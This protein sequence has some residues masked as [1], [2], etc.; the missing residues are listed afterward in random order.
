MIIGIDMDSV[1]ADLIE[2]LNRFH[3]DRYGTTLTLSDYT[4]YDLSNIWLCPPDEVLAR[5]FEFYESP[6]MDE[7]PVMPGAIEGV[8]YL[9]QKHTLV[10][11]TSRPLLTEKKTEAWIKYNFPGSFDKVV[12][13][14][15]VSSNDEKKRTKAEIGKELGIEAMI[16]DHIDYVNDCVENGITSYL[17]EAPWNKGKFVSEGIFHLKDWQ[18]V[19]HYF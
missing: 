11:I 9:K 1:L 6:Y 15:Q 12:L 13:S 5:I 8:A 3:C 10:L 7:I 14:N 2:P 19:K 18:E 17:F 4:D 16:D